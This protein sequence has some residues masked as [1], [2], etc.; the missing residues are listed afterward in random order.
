MLNEFVG[1]AA[2]LR[3]AVQVNPYDLDGSSAA[4]HRA[5]TM[6]GGERR[7]RVR[8]MRERVREYDVHAWSAAFL[9]SLESA[10]A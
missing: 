2:E 5:L 1:A 8:A 7:D 6:P 4:Y 3:E 9:S 10:C